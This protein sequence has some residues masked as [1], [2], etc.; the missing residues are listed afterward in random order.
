M[1]T[2]VYSVIPAELAVLNLR[3]ETAQM[4]PGVPGGLQSRIVVLNVI[5]LI[6]ARK[7][8]DMVITMAVSVVMLHVLIAMTV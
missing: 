8:A 3:V 6:S 1:V 2:S 5:A 4:R 7:A